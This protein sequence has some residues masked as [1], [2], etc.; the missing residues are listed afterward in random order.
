MWLQCW[1]GRHRWKT[2]ATVDGQNFE[3]CRCGHRLTTIY[4]ECTLS[5]IVAEARSISWQLM[6]RL[7]AEPVFEP[8]APQ[9][10]VVQ[11][12]LDAYGRPAGFAIVRPGTASTPERLEALQAGL[13]T[14]LQEGKFAVLEESADVHYEFVKFDY[15]IGVHHEAEA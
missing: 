7:P 10:T 3:Q 8:A 12:V 14:W 15:L 1:F 13:M 5:A 2:V 6:Q 9:P 11:V 4:P